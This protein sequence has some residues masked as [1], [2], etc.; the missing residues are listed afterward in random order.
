MTTAAEARMAAIRARAAGAAAVDVATEHVDA[1][2]PHRRVGFPTNVGTAA[3]VMRESLRVPIDRDRALDVVARFH[4]TGDRS[5]LTA[6]T[7]KEG[8][9]VVK[10]V[11]DALNGKTG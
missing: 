3:T 11:T 2:P 8:A 6:Y 4:L 10:A 1:V 5:W 7:S 9:R